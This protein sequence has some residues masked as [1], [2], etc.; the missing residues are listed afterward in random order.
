[1]R[2]IIPRIA[3]VLLEYKYSELLLYGIILFHKRDFTNVSHAR[4]RRTFEGASRIRKDSTHCTSKH[5]YIINR[6][7]SHVH[8][9]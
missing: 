2:S 3:I 1:M 6:R 5:I 9:I 8:V 7:G 4:V